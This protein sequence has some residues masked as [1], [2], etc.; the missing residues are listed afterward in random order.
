MRSAPPLPIRGEGEAVVSV[1]LVPPIACVCR[2]PSA[3]PL[4]KDDFMHHD[5]GWYAG[6]VQPTCSSCVIEGA[7]IEGGQAHGVDKDVDR[8]DFPLHNGEAH[9]RQRPTSRDSDDPGRAV[10]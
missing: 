7:Q 3:T 5:N 6:S 4:S 8:D 9:D 1:E 2:K 10:D